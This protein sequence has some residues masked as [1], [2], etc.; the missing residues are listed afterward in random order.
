MLSPLLFGLGLQIVGGL[1][2]RRLLLVVRYAMGVTVLLH[3]D[4]PRAL[5]AFGTCRSSGVV[6]THVDDVRCVLQVEA[7]DLMEGFLVLQSMAGGTGA[8]LG[9]AVSEALSDEFSST[10]TMNCCVW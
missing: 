7:C 5:A 9:T 6:S 4:S 10:L 3:M 1:R 8:G 2:L